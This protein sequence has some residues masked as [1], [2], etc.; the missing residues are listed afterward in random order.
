M[1]SSDVDD[2]GGRL[3]TVRRLESRSA[4]RGAFGAVCAAAALLVALGVVIDLEQLWLAGLVGLGFVGLMTA[5]PV[6][7]R[8]DWS[9][10]RGAVLVIASFLAV[11]AAYLVMQYIARAVQWSAPNTASALAAAVLMFLVCLPALSRLARSRAGR[12]RRTGPGGA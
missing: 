7:L 12:A 1:K 3:E 11:I 2:A 5:R 4:R 10:A 8:L 6:R 9:D